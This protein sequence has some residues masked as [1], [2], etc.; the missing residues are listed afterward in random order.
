FSVKLRPAERVPG[1]RPGM[2]VLFDWPR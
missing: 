2:S 1:L